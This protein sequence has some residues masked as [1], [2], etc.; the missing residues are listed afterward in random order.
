MQRGTHVQ[1]FQ[2]EP[3]R[4][5]PSATQASQRGRRASWWSQQSHCAGR[6]RWHWP[7]T[8][9]G[10]KRNS[11]RAVEI[12]ASW[13]CDAHREEVYKKPDWQH[14]GYKTSSS[15]QEVDWLNDVQEDLVLPVLDAL[16]PPGDSVGDCSGRSR[17]AS[18]QLVAL[19]GYVS[20][21]W[22]N[23][24]SEVK[25]QRVGENNFGQRRVLTKQQRRTESLG[26]I[27][28]DHLTRFCTQRG[29]STVDCVSITLYV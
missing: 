24:D 27:R 14:G 2:T 10:F 15:Y 20:E 17:G 3:Y 22:K 13:C 18:V 1:C 19:L 4:W 6:C 23:V 9:V 5:G 25:T 12:A 11:L 28:E 26:L 21:I 7:G 8:Q 16:W 29:K